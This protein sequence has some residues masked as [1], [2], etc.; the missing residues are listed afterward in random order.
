M[1]IDKDRLL[2]QL[3]KSAVVGFL[4]KVPTLPPVTSSAKNPGSD[5]WMVRKQAEAPYVA[6]PQ[7]QAQPV[8][9]TPVAQTTV[10]A[11]P[12]APSTPD[13]KQLLNSISNALG[14]A[15]KT[16][17]NKGTQILGATI[18]SSA[19]PPKGDPAGVDRVWDDYTKNRY[20]VGTQPPPEQQPAS[21]SI[22]GK[23]DA[24][25]KLRG[26][27]ES[28]SKWSTNQAAAHPAI[29]QLLNQVKEFA[30]PA[31][32]A[33]NPALG[34]VANTAVS[35]DTAM[36]N[37]DNFTVWGQLKNTLYVAWTNPGKYGS[38]FWA[39]IQQ[40]FQ[41]LKGWIGGQPNNDAAKQVGAGMAKKSSQN[42]NMTG[43]SRCLRQ[44]FNS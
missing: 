35:A 16:V 36:K 39:W 40:L 1:V 17:V 30:T 20:A 5:P 4:P 9:A 41:S 2:S 24:L 10:K 42:E 25:K 8:A 13:P 18:G 32:T 38:R 3:T 7:A 6:P 11:T 14:N 28:Y 34:S 26:Y 23:L 29:S 44:V 19:T 31:A 37:P 33:I 27:A 22:S 21:S 15:S 43:V 12:A